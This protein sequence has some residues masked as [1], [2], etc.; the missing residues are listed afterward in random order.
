MDE[1]KLGV[2]KKY[3]FQNEDVFIDNIFWHFRPATNEK[4]KNIHTKSS[5]PGSL[6]KLLRKQKKSSH[7]ILK[8]TSVL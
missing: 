4:Q 8:E 5:R 7:Y 1:S 6:Q 2:V 3:E